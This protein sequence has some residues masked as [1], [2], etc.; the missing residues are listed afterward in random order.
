MLN[1]IYNLYIRQDNFMQIGTIYCHTNIINGK[2]Y[3]GQTTKVPYTMRWERQENSY[4]SSPK[5][6]NAIKKY[7]WQNFT[8]E[9]VKQ[10]QEQDIQSLLDKLNSLEE[11][12]II[13]YNTIVDGYN[14]KSN[15]ENHI[16]SDDV[17]TR[18]KHSIEDKEWISNLSKAFIGKN[19]S[20]MEK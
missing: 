18:C 13:K 17:K 14:Q 2:K 3:I 11:Y 5:F 16:V 1:Y 7:G 19:G 10:I 15:G 4:K 12:Y 9:I 8:H 6:H 20:L